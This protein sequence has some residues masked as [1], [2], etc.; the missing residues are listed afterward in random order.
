[1]ARKFAP[2]DTVVLRRDMPEH[3]LRAGD[4]G[5]LVE[6]HGE[7][8]LEAEFGGFEIV[9]YVP[10]GQFETHRG[11]GVETDF[12]TKLGI[13]LNQ[14]GLVDTA[15]SAG[16]WRIAAHLA[17][18]GPTEPGCVHSCQ[19]RHRATGGPAP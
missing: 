9:A 8:G 16:S 13:D 11:H 6:I 7:H 12:R 19:D 2:L 1:V 15:G 3:G 18:S 5:A 14:W 10:T 17:G 4:L